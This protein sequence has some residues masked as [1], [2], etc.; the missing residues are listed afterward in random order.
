MLSLM[1][2]AVIFSMVLGYSM[3]LAKTIFLDSINK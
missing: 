3:S 1:I 2:I